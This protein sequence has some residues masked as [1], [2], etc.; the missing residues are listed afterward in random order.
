M[1]EGKELTI[2]AWVGRLK[3]TGRRSYGQMSEIRDPMYG[4]RS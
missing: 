1:E 4:A 2:T 3:A